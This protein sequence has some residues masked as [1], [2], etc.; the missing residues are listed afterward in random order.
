MSVIFDPSAIV[1]KVLPR[2]RTDLLTKDL[3]FKDS[4][5]KSLL[6]L[7][8]FSGKDLNKTIDNTLSFYKDKMK[9]LKGEG[10]KAFKSEAINDGK[11]LEAR[12]SNLIQ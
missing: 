11:L 12:V 1:K 4:L 9:E 5:K 6:R 2:D 8:W 3:K 10:T 7:N